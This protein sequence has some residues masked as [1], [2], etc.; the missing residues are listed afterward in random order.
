MSAVTMREMFEAGVHFGHQTRFWN[1]KMEPYLYG[2]RNKIHIIDLEKTFPLFIDA[3]NSVGKLASRKQT[4]LFVGTKKSAQ[5]IIKE[6]ATRCSMP[7]INRRWLGGLLTN[8]KT[9]KQSITRLKLLEDLESDGS[10]GRMSKKEALLHMRELDKLRSN[11][12]GIKDMA[13]IPQAIFIIDV[14]FESIAVQEAKKLG[15]SVIGVVDSN[16]NPD[17]IDYPI[18][19]NDDAIRSIQLYSRCIAD[20]ILDGRGSIIQLEGEGDAD[21]FVE[22]DEDGALIPNEAV[23]KITVKSKKKPRKKVALA[24]TEKVELVDDDKDLLTVPAKD[25]SEPIEVVQQPDD[26]EVASSETKSETA[27]KKAKTTKKKIAK[28]KIAKKTVAKKTVAKKK[29]TKKKTTSQSAAKDKEAS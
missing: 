28:K 29:V 2:Q 17:G 5:K 19:G 26:A 22:L 18:P 16:N 8:F 20:A 24:N 27:S 15:I 9:V 10:M 13:G 4:I 25:N 7:Y 1:P 21:D 11:F 3:I 14:G 12:S 23:K 6:E